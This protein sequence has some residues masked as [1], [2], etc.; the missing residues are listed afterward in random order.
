MA[1]IP[2]FGVTQV[3]ARRAAAIG[4]A[5]A[6]NVGGVAAGFL[7]ARAGLPT[8]EGAFAVRQLSSSVRENSAAARHPYSSSSCC[9]ARVSGVIVRDS[10]V[11]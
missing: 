11:L 6:A 1:C 10:L 3:F 4:A 5:F 9:S 8:F 2:L 7:I